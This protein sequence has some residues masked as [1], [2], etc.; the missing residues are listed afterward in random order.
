MKK[1]KCKTAEKQSKQKI[2]LSEVLDFDIDFDIAQPSSKKDRFESKSANKEKRINNLYQAYAGK[3]KPFPSKKQIKE[4]IVISSGQ[5]KFK[6]STKGADLVLDSNGTDE[7]VNFASGAPQIHRKIIEHSLNEP[8][9]AKLELGIY[10][11]D[12]KPTTML[13]SDAF[14]RKYLVN[15]FD[16]DVIIYDMSAFSICIQTMSRKVE[17]EHIHRYSGFTPDG[18]HYLHSGGVISAS[19]N[20]NMHSDP[21]MGSMTLENFDVPDKEIASCLDDMIKLNPVM[22]IMLAVMI[23]SLTFSKY[24]KNTPKFVFILYGSSGTFKSTI[25]RHIFGIHK[26]FYRDAPVNVKITSMPS[27]HKIQQAFRDCVCL[28]DDAAPSVDGNHDTMAKCE[29]L[30]RAAGDATGRIIMGKNGKPDKHTPVGLSA[31]TAEFFPLRD[32]SDIAR[33]LIYELKKGDISKKQLSKVQEAK[34]AYIRFITD[35]IS[36]ICSLEDKYLEKLEDKYMKH[37]SQLKQY[38]KI[39]ARI[40]ENMAWISAAF[41]MICKF[42]QKNYAIPDK[43]IKEWK[44]IFSV[45]VENSIQIQKEHMKMRR[46][47]KLFINTINDTLMSKQVSVSQITKGNNNKNVAAVVSNTIGY[48]DDDWIYLIPDKAY[49]ITNSYLKSFSSGYSLPLPALQSK[50]KESGYIKSGDNNRT[51]HR[52]TVN[53]VRIKVLRF[54]KNTFEVFSQNK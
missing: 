50:L 21:S 30:T 43:Q 32:V 27:L 34:P 28:A 16:H 42:C 48:Y 40:P 4:G 1:K 2:D 11:S 39:H 22:T 6:L 10:K 17:P 41:D 19:D 45:G 33:S 23:L 31:I 46:E 51:L 54:K 49:G 7:L 18:Y 53:G 25:S 13:M 52:L 36:W 38:G 9:L 37:K 3:G 12:I 35:Y 14:N 26:E 44:E 29:S 24:G 47:D 15:H 5:E 20:A 8:P